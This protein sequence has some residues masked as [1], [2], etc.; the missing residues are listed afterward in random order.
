MTGCRAD[1]ASYADATLCSQALWEGLAALEYDH[2]GEI[3]A[4]RWDKRLIPAGAGAFWTQHSP[5]ATMATWAH[6]AGVGHNT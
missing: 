6:K 3:W 1:L 4:P 5:R 2:E